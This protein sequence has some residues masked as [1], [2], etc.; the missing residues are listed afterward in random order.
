MRAGII[1]FLPMAM[2]AFIPLNALA[3]DSLTPGGSVRAYVV[4][5][6]YPDGRDSAEALLMIRLKLSGEVS[7]QL[8]FEL[9]YE[10]VPTYSDSDAA[11][12]SSGLTESSSY[13]PAYRIDDL[14][15]T[16][17]P[18]SPGP[19]DRFIVPQNLDRA[20]ISFAAEEFDLTAGRQPISFGSARVINPTDVLSP[21][22]YETLAKEEKTGIDAIRIRIPTGDFSE[23]DIGIVLGED[24]KQDE[25]AAYVRVKSYL[26]ETDIGFMVMR[27]GDNMMMGI[28][29]A[30]AI[31]EASAWVEATY[32]KPAKE[33]YYTDNSPYTRLSIGADMAFTPTMYGYIE[34]H[35][36]GPGASE[37]GDYLLN[38]L[39]AAYIEGSVYLLGRN[40]LAPGLTVEISPLLSANAAALINIDDSSALLAPSLTYSVSDNA[41]ASIGAYVGTG[42]VPEAEVPRSEF[43]SYPDTWYL[44]FKY[45]F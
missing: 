15:E 45:Y 35:R 7:S 25:G 4:S 41:T 32:T 36:N 44:S 12:E 22:T 26:N 21:F 18:S 14:H 6:E 37:P 39:N 38:A 13:R 29:V 16:L 10:A 31:G 24:A 27:Y 19:R 17:Y 1:F 5:T 20:F 28:D 8:R 42:D 34:Y 23:L 40:Y 3:L 2:L 30:R 43:G 11:D 33:I 9:A